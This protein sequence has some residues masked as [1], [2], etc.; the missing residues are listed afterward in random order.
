MNPASDTKDYP[1]L[2]PLLDAPQAARV[3]GISEQTI[4]DWACQGRIEKVKVGTRLKFKP[5]TLR[6][7]IERHTLPAKVQ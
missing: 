1:G 4:R 5:A 2:E 6:A 3:L 7:F